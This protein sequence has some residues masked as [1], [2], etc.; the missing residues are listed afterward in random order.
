M[1]Y[2]KLP[3]P[4]L[5]QQIISE[6]LDFFIHNREI[7]DIL[8]E[9]STHPYLP[10]KKFEAKFNHSGFHLPHDKSYPAAHYLWYGLT[11]KRM[12]MSQP[13]QI[14]VT[15]TDRTFRWVETS[16]IKKTLHDFDMLVGGNSFSASY[17]TD[18]AS[19]DFFVRKNLI[20]E[21]IASSQ[22]E[23]AAVTRTEAKRLI[24]NKRKPISKSEQM[25]LNNYRTILKIENDIKNYPLSKEILLQLHQEMTKNTLDDETQSGRW[26][27]DDD[28]IVIQGFIDGEEQILYTPPDA[29]TLQQELDRFLRYA[30]NEDE[31]QTTFTHPVIKALLLHFWF[32]YL[33]PFCDGNGRLSRSIF[34]WYLLR[35]NY[36]LVGYVPISTLLKD[37]PGQYR[38]AF[39]YT[40]QYEDDLTYFIDYNLTKITESMQAFNNHVAAVKKK[41]EQADKLTPDLRLN[42]RQK[43][44]INHFI[45]KPT[46]PITSHRHAAFHQITWLTANKDLKELQ[47]AGYLMSEKRSREVIYLP[48]EKLLRAVNA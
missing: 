3:Q 6:S 24:N 25:V 23:G 37:S 28:Q 22:L 47:T 34:F 46:E 45:N 1:D 8:Y 21:A 18:Q 10:W 44:I 4:D 27:Q 7:F 35:Y 43:Q 20:E 15:N 38:D 48:T 36:Y 29:A 2:F 32:A 19:R 39:L 26:R 14:K 17:Q 33:H 31:D 13:T 12:S 9:N 11:F 41:R 30:N 16:F 40:E 5:N 42:D